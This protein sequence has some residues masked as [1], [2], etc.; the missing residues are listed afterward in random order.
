MQQMQ[1]CAKVG[2]LQLSHRCNAAHHKITTSEFRLKDKS[3]AV[4]IVDY[5]RDYT[6][7]DGV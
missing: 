1:Q 6:V 3:G 2:L 5:S 4:I 7:V